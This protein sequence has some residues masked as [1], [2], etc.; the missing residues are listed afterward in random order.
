MDLGQIEKPTLLLDEARA[1]HNLERMA[2]KARRLGLRFRPHFKTHQSAE[3][4]EWFRK[5][6]VSGI[7]VSS[8]DM[9]QYF[10]AAGW[11]DIL[12]AFST[13]P[14]Q[15]RALDELAGRIHLEVLVESPETVTFLDEHLTHTVDAWIEV[16]VGQ[17]RTGIPVEEHGYLLA[18]ARCMRGTKLHLRGL[19]AHAGQ[20]YHAEPAEI[21]AICQ[22]SITD[23]QRAREALARGG[24]APCELSYGDT[25]S[26]TLVEDLRGLDEIRPGNFIFYD[27]MQQRLGVCPE[28]D[29]AV[30]VA[31]P[32]VAKHAER[33]A[34]GTLYRLALYGGAIH[35]SKEY[36]AGENGPIYGG[37]AHLSAKG[38]GELLPGAA[39]YS[40]SQ[41][42]GL[43]RVSVARYDAFQVGDLAA[44]IPVHSCLTVD[45]YHEYLTVEGKR[46]G[47]K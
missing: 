38:W 9:A 44:V 1:R 27:L 3:M 21:D 14:R 2:L 33:G 18:L 8:V 35:L 5:E 46:I 19:L 47:I 42:H 43:A 24:I 31:C 41:E 30:A 32:V 11:Q 34:N 26:C 7:T 6:G 20:T 10:A 36:L 25:P 40:L 17:H 37:L 15:A 39:L 45:L 12:I 29:I 28:T 16:D 22:R 4:G 23:M 13:N